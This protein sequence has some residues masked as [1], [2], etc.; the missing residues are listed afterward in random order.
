[1]TAGVRARRQ[2]AT[3]HL[4]G[5]QAGRALR[6]LHRRA[7]VVPPQ[8]RSPAERHASQGG[9]QAGRARRR[10]SPA[11][12][13]GPASE[14]LACDAPRV[15]WAVAIRTA[16]CAG[17]IGAPAS[18]ASVALAWDPPRVTSAGRQ[19]GPRAGPASSARRRGPPPRRSPAIHRASPGR[20]P[21]GPRAARAS[22]ARRRGPPRWRLPAMRHASPGQSPGG[23][24]AA[25][26]SSV[27]RRGPPRRRSPAMRHASP[28]RSPRRTARGAGFIGAP[29]WS[30]SEAFACD[31]PR[32][33]WA[34]ARRTAR[35]AGFTGALAWSASEAFTCDAPRVTWAVTKADRALHRLHRRASVVRL[36]G[37]HLRCA[38][39][40][41]GGRQ[42]DRALRRLHRRASAVPPRRRVTCDAPRVAWA[43][44]RRTARCAGFI[45]APAWSASEARSRRARRVTCPV[46]RRAARLRRL[47]RR[48]GVVRLGGA[49][50]RY[51][52]RHL[53]G[54]QGGR[55]LRRLHRRAGMVRLGGAR[56]RSATRHLGGRQGG[57]CAAPASLARGVVHL[58]GARVRP[59]TR[60]LGSRQGGPW[61]C[62]RCPRLRKRAGVLRLR[63]G[64]LLAR[65]SA[66][67]I[68]PP[69]RPGTPTC[70]SSW[71]TTTDAARRRSVA[72]T[73]C[74][75]RFEAWA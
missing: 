64:V 73:L 16:R 65:S 60:D 36:G 55:A 39:R 13:R 44:A 4:G 19:G 59:A 8:G 43:V 61:R 5:H 58:G 20:S 29:A 48:A 14:A 17:F 51:A 63:S 41:L 3:R 12:R 74:S 24:R 69:W 67:A 38:T 21:G 57:P 7:G 42:A 1:M 6:R 47:H 33:T 22:S 54:L 37:A 9:H 15:T 25:P 31:A 71:R 46:A 49:H 26:A 28:G 72:R 70:R 53:G 50:P 18:S 27:R 62:A 32:V 2:R 75:F 23:P 35:C 30:V 66:C 68:A 11:R 34:V 10:A 45:G 56:L 40:H 52:T